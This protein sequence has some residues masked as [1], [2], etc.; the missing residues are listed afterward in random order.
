MRYA[1][2]LIAM[3]ME[4]ETPSVVFVDVDDSGEVRT[5][6]AVHLWIEMTDG[7]KRLDLRCLVH[8]NV[9]VNGSDHA[10][11]KAVFEA[12]VRAGAARVRA[13]VITTTGQGEFMRYAAAQHADTQG[14]ISWL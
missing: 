5:F 13:F 8:L 6:S 4:D 9:V 12:A 14:E 1:K 11:V 2:E 7:V 3:R 10:R